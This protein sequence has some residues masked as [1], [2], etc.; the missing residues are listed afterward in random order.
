M[1]KLVSDAPAHL[2]VTSML[3]DDLT[4]SGQHGIPPNLDVTPADCLDESDMQVDFPDGLFPLYG[5][6]STDMAGIEDMPGQMDDPVEEFAP[7]KRPRGRPRGSKKSKRGSD[8][9]MK[10]STTEDFQESKTSGGMDDGPIQ[11]VQDLPQIEKKIQGRQKK[12]TKKHK[13]KQKATENKEYITTDVVRGKMGYDMAIVTISPYENPAVLSQIRAEMSSDPHSTIEQGPSMQASSSKV[14][15]STDLPN[16]VST[17]VLS[18]LD[19]LV[20]RMRRLAEEY[21]HGGNVD[22]EAGHIHI[23]DSVE[24]DEL[25]SLRTYSLW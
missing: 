3:P 5:A 8:A 25:D 2:D 20:D 1:R 18:T 6:E 4:S 16:D 13:G 17:K 11:P 15:L 19:D 23:L 14:K 7:I 21:K 24:I 12:S 22:T 10:E 9:Y